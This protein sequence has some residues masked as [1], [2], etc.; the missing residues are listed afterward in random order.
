MR[1]KYELKKTVFEDIR[2]LYLQGKTQKEICKIK[3]LKE[4]QV[5]RYIT[6]VV[7]ELR[8]IKEVDRIEQAKLMERNIFRLIEKNKDVSHL[9]N[10]F[11][12]FCA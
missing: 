12:R 11:S 6:K 10:E 5:Y 4:W 7:N 3:D 8:Y 9:V 2:E 1:K